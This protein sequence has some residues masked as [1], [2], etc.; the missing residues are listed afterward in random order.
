MLDGGYKRYIFEYRFDGA[1]WGVE[2]VAKSPLEAKERMK[3]LTWARYRGE[4]MAKIPIPGAGLIHRIV[5]RCLKL[6]RDR[7]RSDAV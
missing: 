6:I 5:T 1:E 4:V 2:I 7:Q 3:T